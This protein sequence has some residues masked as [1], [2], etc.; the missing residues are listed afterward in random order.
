MHPTAHKTEP[1]DIP[2]GP[3]ERAIWIQ[4]RDAAHLHKPK[5]PQEPEPSQTVGI[6]QQEHRNEDR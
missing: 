6:Q 1:T 3:R 4:R 5:R 2:D